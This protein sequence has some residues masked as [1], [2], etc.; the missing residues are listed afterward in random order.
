MTAMANSDSGTGADVQ[1]KWTVVLPYLLAALIAILFSENVAAQNK[2]CRAQARE[3]PRI[4]KEQANQLCGDD[5]KGWPVRCY[6][7]TR[8]QSP[9]RLS[10]EKSLQFCAKATNLWRV[11][12]LEKIHSRWPHDRDRIAAFCK[13]AT[14][15][16]AANC[17]VEALNDGISIDKALEDCGDS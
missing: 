12:C 17:V 3:K 9:V 13:P 2:G 10:H 4:A 16:W 15:L 6:E 7:Q 11:R 1:G 14:D 8:G 5:K